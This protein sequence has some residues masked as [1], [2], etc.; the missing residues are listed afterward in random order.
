MEIRQEAAERIL[1]RGVRFSLPAPVFSRL[2]KLN[3]IVIKPLYPGTILE[4][5]TVVLENNLEKAI[6]LSR[7]EVLQKSIKPIATCMAIAIL[8]DEKKIAKR[9][10]KLQKWL[11]WKVPAELLIKMFLV[12]SG[13]NRTADFTTITKYFVIQ[14]SMMMNPNLG[15]ETNGR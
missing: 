8:N 1:N 6:T 5:A 2:L 9:K 13:M 7:Y 3:R 4:F 11:L 15:Q 10:D 12:V 14:T